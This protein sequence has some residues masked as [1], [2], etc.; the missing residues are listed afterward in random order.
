MKSK[1]RYEIIIYWSEE[2]KAYIAEVPELPGCAADGATYQTRTYSQLKSPRTSAVRS[3]KLKASL[4]I[5]NAAR[6]RSRYRSCR[7]NAPGQNRPPAFPFGKLL[8]IARRMK[9]FRAT[10]PETSM[11][12]QV[13]GVAPNDDPA[14]LP[15]R[16]YKEAVGVS[17]IRWCDLDHHADQVGVRRFKSTLNYLLWTFKHDI[18]KTSDIQLP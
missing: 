4:G 14:Q 10:G 7:T 12:R 16:E 13:P 5:S 6:L 3:I 18:S 2:D 1:H 9:G 8:W 11:F 15:P 17:R